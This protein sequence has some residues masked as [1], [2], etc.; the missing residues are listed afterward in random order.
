MGRVDAQRQQ[1]YR[2][3]R[4]GDIDSTNAEALRR[5][6]SGDCGPLWIVAERQLAGRGRRGRYWVSEPGNLY[7]SL[8][9]APQCEPR[10][11]GQIAFVAGVAV[12][13]AICAI[14]PDAAAGLA[15]KWPND[16][17]YRNAKVAGILIES[18]GSAELECLVVGCGVNCATSPPDTPYRATN[19]ASEGLVVP[20]EKL[21]E[22]LAASFSY[23]LDEWQ[24]GE[25]FAAIR[26]A[27]L[28]SASG[29]GAPIIVRLGAEDVDGIFEGLG[30]DG[31]LILRRGDGS[32]RS[33]LT[34]DIF[35][36]PPAGTAGIA[37]NGH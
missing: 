10:H 27:W 36:R 35:F 21:A 6:A 28:R 14:A 29:I 32:R 9:F 31:Q 16:L 2:I 3:E 18:A 13:D 19:F 4:F 23:R 24:R 17:L 1:T 20:R 37:Q 25:N 22:E 15:L 34:G 8:L 30:A 11:A 5:A 7:A 26:E 33:I 12:R